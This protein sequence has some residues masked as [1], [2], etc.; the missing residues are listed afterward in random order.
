MSK[1][2][3]FQFCDFFFSF[4]TVIKNTPVQSVCLLWLFALGLLFVY[5]V[6]Y[7]VLSEGSDMHWAWGCACCHDLFPCVQWRVRLSWSQWSHGLQLCAKESQ[8]A[9]SAKWAEV[10]QYL[11]SGRK[12][13]TNHC[14]VSSKSMRKHLVQMLS[15]SVL[16]SFTE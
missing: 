14:K 2:I 16:F 8:P 11:Y 12:S 6:F 7:P 13:I 1:Q 9:L 4:C 10:Y 3:L 15:P 5:S